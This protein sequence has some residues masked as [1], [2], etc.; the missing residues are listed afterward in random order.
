MKKTSPD[1]FDYLPEFEILREEQ[2]AAVMGI[3]DILHPLSP[4]QRRELMDELHAWL[5]EEYGPRARQPAL[6]S[7]QLGGR[8]KL[9]KDGRKIE[10][11]RP[12]PSLCRKDAKDR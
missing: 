7:V 8:V 12:R 9:V 2:K 6:T 11:D 10:Q 5:E 1:A 4:R 3:L